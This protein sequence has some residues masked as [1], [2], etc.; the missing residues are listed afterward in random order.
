MAIRFLSRFSSD[1]RRSAATRRSMVVSAAILGERGDE[2][3]VS[4]LEPG[5]ATW[6]FL[7]AVAGELEPRKCEVID[8]FAFRCRPDR[9][10]A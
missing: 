6:G 8:G 9:I 3:E 1:A 2:G 4:W 10:A 5:G 7:I